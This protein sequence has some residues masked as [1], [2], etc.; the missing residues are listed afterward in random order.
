LQK[1]T[2]VYRQIIII[3]KTMGLNH[4]AASF[5][6]SVELVLTRNILH[7]SPD[8]L[9]YSQKGFCRLSYLEFT[10]NKWFC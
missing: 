7:S 4:S 9:W 1:V 5:H 10:W 6:D 8:C 2:A 3:F